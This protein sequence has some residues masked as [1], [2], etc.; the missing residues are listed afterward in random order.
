MGCFA[1]LALPF[2]ELALFLWLGGRMGFLKLVALLIG[3]GILGGAL[4][5]IEGLRTLRTI[6]SF[7]RVGQVPEEGKISALLFLVG[8]VLLAFPGLISDVLGLILVFPPTRALVVPLVLA[9]LQESIRRGSFTLYVGTEEPPVDPSVLA[10]F[11]DFR[12]VETEPGDAPRLPEQKQDDPP[13][14]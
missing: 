12:I 8:C 2:A 13:V 9:R 3:M 1:V 6:R 7:L 4:A 14:R 5:R 11:D 10:T